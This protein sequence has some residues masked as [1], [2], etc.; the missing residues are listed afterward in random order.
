[1]IIHVFISDT[2]ILQRRGEGINLPGGDSI[3]STA[4]SCEEHG[5]HG[6]EAGRTGFEPATE[7]PSGRKALLLPGVGE[8]GGDKL[9]KSLN[10][11]KSQLFNKWNLVQ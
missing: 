1:M 7:G 2:Q 3:S 10:R 8:D 4:G 6:K 9:R 5:K 11:Q